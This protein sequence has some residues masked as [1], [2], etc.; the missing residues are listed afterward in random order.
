MSNSTVVSGMS[1]VDTYLV[2]ITQC[3][4]CRFGWTNTITGDVY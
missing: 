4:D 2:E 3:K 1:L